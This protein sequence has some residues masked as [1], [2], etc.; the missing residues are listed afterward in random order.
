VGLQLLGRALDEATL[1]RV[2]HGFQQ[3][4]DHHGAVPDL[5]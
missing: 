4:T 5:P 2:A 3:R 1:F